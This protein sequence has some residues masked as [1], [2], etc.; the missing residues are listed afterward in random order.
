MPIGKTLDDITNTSIFVNNRSAETGA[1]FP[2]P[3]LGVTITS[4]THYELWRSDTGTAVDYRTEIVEW[5]TAGLAIRQTHYHF[6]V[7]NDTID[8]TDPWPL[9]AANLG[10]DTILT[11]TDEPLGEGERIRIRMALQAQNATFP[12]GTK[13][14]KLQYGLL[15]TSCAAI[16]ESNWTTL[17]DSASS[18]IWRGY[19]AP[20]V[21]DGTLLSGD[22]PTLGDLNLPLSDVAGT[23]EE[24]N[25]TE[26]NTFAVPEG[27]EIEY[28][29]LIEQNGAIA[30]SYYCFRMVEA[31]DTV[32]G[33]YLSYPQ[34][35]TASFTPRTQN[36]RWYTDEA[37]VTPTIA[38]AGENIAPANIA[39]DEVLKLRVT[40]KETKNIFRDD[41]RFKLQ[42]SEQANFQTAHELAPSGSC[43]A[44]ST[45][46][47]ADGAGTDNAL[48][49]SKVLSDA[50]SCTGGVGDGCG[51]HNES[52]DVLT[53]FRHENSAAAEYEFTI[54][55]AGPRVNRVYYF[56][57]Y[58][59]ALDIPV[60]VNT[61]ESYPSLTTE[62]ASLVFAMEG[63][64]SGT[65]IEGVTLD[66]ATAPSAV[67]FGTVPPNAMIEGAHRLGVDTNG[68]QGY[69]LFMTMTSDLLSSGGSVI[70][71]VSGTN[72]APTAWASGC[73]VDAT[74]C[75]GYHTSDDTLYGGSTRFSAVD[76]YARI[77]T[78]TLD[79]VGYSSQPTL[80]D[81]VDVVF[82][83]FIRQLQD[84]GTYE[85]H[86]QYVSVPIF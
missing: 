15:T 8:P 61:G 30:D 22:P 25:D 33:A 20:G 62:G 28:D 10:E 36:W 31:N 66:I 50:D 55:S 80:T 9:G 4:T 60:S 11:A 7:D 63:V 79:E 52:S 74:S 43:T 77:S 40:V 48:I 65:T 53:G 32:L 82:R 21:I 72:G 51:T 45:W 29:W 14:F 27:D 83:I 73:A 19:N 84:A 57:L 34:L 23:F 75:F 70:E 13:A 44:T 26:V 64:S 24:E 5:P 71:Q 85:A 54:R 12:A 81:T 6:F 39:N 41:V 56:R 16:S 76:T 86:I 42:Y 49:A 58:D 69:Q 78:T 59:L 2:R 46:C 67:P 38:L 37:Q 17:G 18:T 35:R 68:T 47:Y 3:I 1:L